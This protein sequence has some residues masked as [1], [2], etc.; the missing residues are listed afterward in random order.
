M[1]PLTERCPILGPLRF[2]C[3]VIHRADGD[4]YIRDTAP[5]FLQHAVG[6]EFFKSSYDLS[7]L[8]ISLSRVSQLDA[9]LLRLGHRREIPER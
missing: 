6:K 5:G 2:F 4:K 3:F 7:A 9:C 1:I 8:S